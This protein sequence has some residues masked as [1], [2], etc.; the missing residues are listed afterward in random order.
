[1]FKN[2]ESWSEIQKK[3]NV[4]WLTMID[5]L[6]RRKKERK[7]EKKKKKSGYNII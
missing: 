7:K 5:N 6:G 3:K 4:Q 2:D 1:M